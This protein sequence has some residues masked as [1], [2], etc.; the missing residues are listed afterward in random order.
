MMAH[1]GAPERPV[2]NAELQQGYERD[3]S[4]QFRSGTGAPSEAL[5]WIGHRHRGWRA[6]DVF[7]I[8][9]SVLPPFQGRGAARVAAAQ[10]IPKSA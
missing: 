1:L 4:V 8:A 3:G 5:G 6:E 2:K 10:V 7:E 9:W